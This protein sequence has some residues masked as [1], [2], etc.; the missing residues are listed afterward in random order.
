[1]ETK[2]WYDIACDIDIKAWKWNTSG[3]CPFYACVFF[4]SYYD[5]IQYK[6]FLSYGDESESS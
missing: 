4:T 6:R 5:C 2:Y 1:M 3:V